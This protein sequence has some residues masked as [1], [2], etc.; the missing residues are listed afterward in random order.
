MQL[1][2]FRN[3]T[4]LISYNA[5]T[6]WRIPAVFCPSIYYNCNGNTQFWTVLCAEIGTDQVAFVVKNIWMQLCFFW[7][8]T[9]LISYIAVTSWIPVIFCTWC[10][11]WML[12]QLIYVT[13]NVSL[14]TDIHISFIYVRFS[15]VLIKLQERRNVWQYPI[16]VSRMKILSTRVLTIWRF[17]SHLRLLYLLSQ[18]VH[19]RAQIFYFPSES[20]F[21]WRIAKCVP[22]FKTGDIQFRINFHRLIRR[23]WA[24]RC[25]IPDPSKC[26][27]FH[28]FYLSFTINL[29]RIPNPYH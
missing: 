17:T 29:A 25:K 6:S 19:V 18:R 1:C 2:F 10:I 21:K 27:R 20:I 13:E 24:M 12:T 4:D 3:K 16:L 14:L 28:Y 8:E 15:R 5:V 26:F 22:V 9:D 11:F 7:N 23:C